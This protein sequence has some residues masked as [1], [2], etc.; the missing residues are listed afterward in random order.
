MKYCLLS[1]ALVCLLA[2]DSPSQE[3]QACRQTCDAYR[4]SVRVEL[5]NA[6]ESG[7]NPTHYISIFHP[8][9]DPLIKF[10]GALERA[11]DPAVAKAPNV[12]SPFDDAAAVY[13]NGQE[14]W[15][16]KW[17]QPNNTEFVLQPR[18]MRQAGLHK[19]VTAAIDYW[20]VECC[21]AMIFADL[22]GTTVCGND[23]YCL[24]YGEALTFTNFPPNKTRESVLFKLGPNGHYTLRTEKF[25]VSE[26]KA[27][28]Q[29]NGEQCSCTDPTLQLDQKFFEKEL[30]LNLK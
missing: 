17:A 22:G 10:R 20:N 29:Q 28:T 5:Q 25:W 27:P 1:V 24:A 16:S 19:V 8:E 14:Q 9:G 26:L 6:A 12:K 13:V 15:I 18:S 23:Q 30:K 21:G 7:V 2:V 11:Y 3:T 4:N